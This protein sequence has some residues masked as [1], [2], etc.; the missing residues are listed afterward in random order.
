MS[1]KVRI[2]VVVELKIPPAGFSSR[3][4]NHYLIGKEEHDSSLIG[5]LS[6]LSESVLKPFSAPGKGISILVRFYRFLTLCSLFIKD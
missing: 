2:Q 4:S 5:Q 1:L 3:E 6:I